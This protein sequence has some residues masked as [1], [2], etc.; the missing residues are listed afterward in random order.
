MKATNLLLAGAVMVASVP[1]FAAND[2][3][4]VAAQPAPVHV[5]MNTAPAAKQHVPRSLT[6]RTARKYPKAERSDAKPEKLVHER[7]VH[8]EDHQY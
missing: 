4:P 3:A 5:A 2:E 6:D 8:D 1:V 7:W